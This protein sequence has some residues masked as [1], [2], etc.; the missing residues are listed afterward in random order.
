MTIEATYNTAP[1]RKGVAIGAGLLVAG[2]LILLPLGLSYWSTWSTELAPHRLSLLCA[3]LALL[4]IELPILNYVFWGQLRQKEQILGT[5]Y[6]EL[7]Y[8]YCYQFWMG[9]KTTRDFTNNWGGKATV[10]VETDRKKAFDEEANAVFDEVLGDIF[11]RWPYALPAILFT[12]I[13]YIVFVIAIDGGLAEAHADTSSLKPFIPFNEVAVS[14]ICGAYLWIAGDAVSRSYRKIFNPSVLNWY[15]L[16][17]VVAVPLGVA[18]SSVKL[19]DNVTTTQAAI[20]FL[21]GTFSFDRLRSILSGIA[22]RALVVTQTAPDENR[23]LVIKLP[24]VDQSVGELLANEGISTI[25]QL[26]SADPVMVSIRAGLSLDFVATLVDSALLWR[27]AAEK[28]GSL[29]ALGIAGASDAIELPARFS[30]AEGQGLEQ[31]YGE[32]A[33][34]AGIT[35]TGLKAIVAALDQDNYAKFICKLLKA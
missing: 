3:S 26:A 10:T 24:G 19:Q 4:V 11:T 33:P 15:S 2:V 27:Y 34:I 21:V 17:L 23:D 29:S 31:Y 14:A 32:T 7:I 6:P 12:A 22:M 9:R 28:I 30:T 8:E 1:P 20:G 35:T 13:A 16:R 18:L 5:Y 25:S